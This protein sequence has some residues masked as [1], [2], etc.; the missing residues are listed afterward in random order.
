MR[1]TVFVS[2]VIKMITEIALS[3]C[4]N[5]SMNMGS[6]SKLF[7]FVYANHALVL[8][9]DPGWLKASLDL[10]KD[11]IGESGMHFVPSKCKMV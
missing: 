3:L 5:R 1:E 10:L 7:D 11:S 4:T 2:P 9:A 8:N 6:K